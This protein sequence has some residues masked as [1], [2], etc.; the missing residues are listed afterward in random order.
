VLEAALCYWAGMP[1]TAGAADLKGFFPVVYLKASAGCRIALEGIG[2]K[3]TFAAA[4]QPN[5]VW[6]WTTK[7]LGRAEGYLATL[8]DHFLQTRSD[9][10]ART[11]GGVSLAA[12]H[13]TF[14]AGASSGPDSALFLAD[15]RR[16]HQGI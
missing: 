14:C 8:A 7:P 15:A 13:D 11:G 3:H 4:P 12:Q 6:A 10:W 1:G 2:W 16:V 5:A 9:A